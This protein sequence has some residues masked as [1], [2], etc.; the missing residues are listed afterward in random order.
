MCYYR[1]F[2]KHSNKKLIEEIKL[3]NE[4]RSEWLLRAYEKAGRLLKRITA[5][6][7][8]KDGNHPV[9]LYSA[10]LVEQRVDYIHNNPVESEIVDEAE[11]YWYSSARDYAGRRGLIDVE[12][13]R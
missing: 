7:L 8:W 2:K 11:N 12:L 13:V 9:E 6:K 3:I 1:D 5:N 10:E 4:S